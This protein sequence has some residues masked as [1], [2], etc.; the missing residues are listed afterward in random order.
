MTTAT[1]VRVQPTTKQRGYIEYLIRTNHWQSSLKQ[2][3]GVAPKEG[4]PKPDCTMA[5]FDKWV[6]ENL[7]VQEAGNLIDFLLELTNEQPDNSQSQ[8]EGK[9]AEIG[10]LF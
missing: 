9:L 1:K 6:L 4:L 8:F 3:E 10:Y 7:D 5:Y 2:V